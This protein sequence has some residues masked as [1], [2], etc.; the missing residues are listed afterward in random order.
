ML[1]SSNFWVWL[2]WNND[3]IWR[4]IAKFLA[5]I[6]ISLKLDFKHI[7]KYLHSKVC[8]KI[9]KLANTWIIFNSYSS[10]NAPRYE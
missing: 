2:D 4:H 10:S 1:G 6:K 3:V 5:R 8:D 9:K 7:Q